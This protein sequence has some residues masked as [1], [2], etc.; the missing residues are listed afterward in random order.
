MAYEATFTKHELEFNNLKKV[1][2]KRMWSVSHRDKSTPQ[3]DIPIFS[4]NYNNWVSFKDL[5]NEAIHNNPALS[6]AQKMQFL[7]ARVKGEAERLIQHLSISADN[8]LT[9]WEILKHRYDNK[10]LIFTSH[11]NILFGLPNIQQTSVSQLKKMHDIAVE[12]LHAIKNLGVDISTWDPILVHILTQ[13]LDSET[14]TEYHASLKNSRELPVLQELLNFLESKFTTLETSSRRK[15]EPT[16]Q[17]P[18]HLQPWTPTYNIKKPI[19]FPPNNN[20]NNHR[21]SGNPNIAKTFHIS[22]IKCPL[23]KYDHGIYNCKTF[24]QMQNDKKLY[25][26]NKL[27]LCINCLFSHN[28]KPCNSA[29]RCRKC[30]NQHNT[31]IHD[32]LLENQS[33]NL[34]VKAVPQRENVASTSHVSQDDYSE[35]LLATALL[36]VLGADGTYHTM[37]ALVDQ[38]SQISIITEHAAQTLGIKRTKCKGVI[39]GVCQRENSSKGKLNISCLSIHN[40]YKFEVEVIIMNNLIKSLP[41]KTFTKP[42]WSL[43]KNINLADPD[44]NISRPVDL[45]LGAD[46]YSNIILHGIIKGDEATEPIAQQTHLGWLLC[47]NARTFQCNVIINNIEDLQQ[48]WEIEEIT[49]DGEMSSEEIQCVQYFEETTKRNEDGRYEVRLPMKQDFEK[50]LGKSKPRALAQFFN[51]EKKLNKHENLAEMYKQFMN[52][53]LQLNHMR[54][55]D[56]NSNMKLECYLPHHGVSHDESSTTKY[57]V[58]FNASDRTSTGRSL[59]DL[60][61]KGPNLQQ[62]LQGLLLKW[63]QYR[64]A[65]HQT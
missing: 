39:Y 52:E 9:C 54:A 6:N 45:L 48:F 43:L 60:M 23:C 56:S 8:Y 11:I 3:L 63:R 53:Y 25:T 41:N 12:T 65:I 42:S 10:K 7:K 40:D 44:F 30:S 29:K 22:N 27:G 64:Y 18:S 33:P 13:K 58:V 55:T 50:E 47:G 46:V 38:G 34:M 2:N 24:L 51:L 5:F 62:D 15:Q 59:N 31:L 32:A 1:L 36:K 61:Y 16:S 20:Y 19:N 49:E 17:K 28:G 21:N 37:R 57:R 14:Y 35:I 26:V 4:G